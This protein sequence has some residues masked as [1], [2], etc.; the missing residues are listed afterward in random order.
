[1]LVYGQAVDWTP[2]LVLWVANG[3]VG[4]AL[5]CRRRLPGVGVLMA[6]LLGPVGVAVGLVERLISEEPY[7]AS[8][9]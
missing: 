4:I 5:G 1:M 6:L 8:E 3:I 7:T 9:R 2:Y